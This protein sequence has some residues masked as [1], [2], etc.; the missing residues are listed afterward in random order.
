MCTE[1]VWIKISGSTLCSLLS[2]YL[3]SYCFQKSLYMFFSTVGAINYISYLFNLF[4]QTSEVFF[5]QAHYD[6]LHVP[7]HV[8]N[9][10]ISTSLHF[11]C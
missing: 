5:G 10:A 6:P 4:F 2:T 8:I 7:V 11:L 1:N 9:L 3:V